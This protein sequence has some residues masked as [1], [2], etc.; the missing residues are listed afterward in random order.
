VVDEE[1]KQQLAALGYIGS[2]VATKPDA[3]L[4]DPKEN[5]GKANDIGRAY[6][7]YLNA[8][9]PEADRLTAELLK[10]N[11]YMVDVW[12][13]RAR[14]LA[15]L[16]RTDE[17]IDCAKEALK[18][19]PGTTSLAAMVASFSLEAKR[20]DDAE[21][22]ARLTLKETPFEAHQ[23]LAQVWLARKDYAKARQEND[24]AEK[25]HPNR[26][27]TA[28][29]R[30]RIIMDG[31]DPE[32][33]LKELDRAA[34]EMARRRSKPAPKLNFY[35]GD[36]LVNLG[37][38]KEAEAAFRKEIE[39]YP[40]GAQPYKNLIVLYA[41]QNR[42]R[43]ATELIFA[44]EKAAPTPATYRAIAD[45]LKVIGDQEGAKFWA[46]RAHNAQR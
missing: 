23:L 37:R 22:H 25:V 33:A 9:Y 7:A 26:P 32:T 46:A 45:V 10:N 2:T 17:A 30:A 15:K 21:K 5:I 4:P 41:L 42:N 1:K 8:N 27:A 35:R 24:L 12:T 20:Y 43:E 38:D 40:T 28:L 6:R 31:G 44:L 36:A 29:I 13:L 18:L 11:A 34:A 19:S 16:N 14:V 3:V 39:L